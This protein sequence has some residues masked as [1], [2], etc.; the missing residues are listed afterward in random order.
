MCSNPNEPLFQEEEE[1]DEEAS[2]STLS[3]H[4]YPSYNPRFTY[5][6]RQKS[7]LGKLRTR[8]IGA[9]SPRYKYKENV[10]D[11]S[12][13]N[14]DSHSSGFESKMPSS[15][16]GWLQK[17]TNSNSE[18]S[19]ELNSNNE[20][21]PVSSIFGL[22]RLNG[23]E[24]NSTAFTNNI[25]SNSK[26]ERAM[27]IFKPM[28][29]NRNIQ[30]N[31]PCHNNEDKENFT[32]P[33]G[34]IQQNTEKKESYQI[35]GLNPN[36]DFNILKPIANVDTD[37]LEKQPKSC[38]LF[39]QRQSQFIDNKLKE[40]EPNCPQLGTFPRIS[41]FDQ[42]TD[43]RENNLFNVNFET[44]HLT[45][46][47]KESKEIIKPPE[48][49]KKTVPQIDVKKQMNENI[50]N[51]SSDNKPPLFCNS[52]KNETFEPF[53]FKAIGQRTIFD[54]PFLFTAGTKSEKE[55]LSDDSLNTPLD[56]S[57]GEY[58]HK[59][60]NSVQ[61]SSESSISED[62]KKCQNIAEATKKMPKNIVIDDENKFEPVNVIESSLL[63][64]NTPQTSLTLVSNLTKK[65]SVHPA[66]SEHPKDS[67][68]LQNQNT[69]PNLS[70]GITEKEHLKPANLRIQ[71]DTGANQFMECAGS[72][73]Y[74]E[75]EQLKK[76]VPSTSDI[77]SK[78]LK[79]ANHLKCNNINNKAIQ[80][81]I[82]N[83]QL[84]MDAITLDNP[85]KSVG[86]IIFEASDTISLENTD[87]TLQYNCNE[88]TNNNINNEH[89]LRTD[90]QFPSQ[91]I[92][93]PCNKNVIPQESEINKAYV[94]GQVL[95]KT[96]LEESDVTVLPQCNGNVN[97]NSNNEL[98]LRT[99]KQFSSQSSIPS[100]I[101]LKAP[102]ESV[103][104]K[105]YKNVHPGLQ[106]KTQMDINIQTMRP[107][108]DNEINKFS[109]LNYNPLSQCST[110]QNHHKVS[111]QHAPTVFNNHQ[112]ES[113]ISFEKLLPSYCA[114]S[115]DFIKPSIP[116]KFGN[117]I[118]LIK[119]KQID[120]AKPISGIQSNFHIPTGVSSR[121]NQTLYVNGRPY[122]ILSTLGKGGSSEV[123]QVLDPTTSNLMAVKCVDLNTVDQSIANGYLNEIAL[124]SRL[125]GCATVIKMF[126]HEYVKEN[127]MLYVVM[128]KG[129]TDLSRLIRDINKTAK[130]SMSMIIYYW[131]EMLTAVRDIHEKGI[132]HSDL[133]PAN[134][135][136]VSGR[137]KLIDFGIA[138]S[139][140]GDMT[141]VQKESTTGTWNYMSPEAFRNSG[142]SGQGIKITYRSDVWSLGC[143]LY[144]LIYGKTP[145]SHITHTWNK[146]QAIADPNHQIDFPAI[147][148]PPVLDQALK[149]C[150][151]RDPKQRPTVKQLLNMPY[152]ATVDKMSLGL[153]VKNILPA[154]WWS[155]V[156]HLFT[157]G[158][159]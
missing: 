45:K 93:F 5:N 130:I 47:F 113:K 90:K 125:Q 146:L 155:T 152:H 121:M 15:A 31:T 76:S 38:S 19:T 91:L 69:M 48:I 68:C 80:S 30:F 56:L 89:N 116:P 88:S 28:N 25:F 11:F 158:R 58:L 44:K 94:N 3:P 120:C 2:N 143:I 148:I 159:K 14:S 17:T 112:V 134:F 65:M 78:E 26:N 141:S 24:Y 12:E 83:L 84:P 6:K 118:P 20:N 70:N 41:R 75:A 124:L 153:Q 35:F 133:K 22:P 49:E 138:S 150:F 77:E 32:H 40:K 144:N 108:S 103:P 147:D 82:N 106:S 64:N 62:G 72:N 100:D 117:R 136:L 139:I 127:K 140:Q 63:K 109:V 102:N 34:K 149:S 51:K 1:E 10:S 129:D 23:Q 13:S 36:R 101:F 157:D 131:T 85:V 111:F 29:C 73:L 27:S 137:L 81:V 115:N 87:A 42:K 21:K 104:N 96:D 142:G 95:E 135:L 61:S 66:S 57:S 50:I 53:L 67:Y 7:N 114:K 9:K 46:D 105:P 55:N 60:N 86:N 39:S 126:A 33:E 79:Q 37:K 8:H 145:F 59:A 16:F 132:I 43:H 122:T 119:E 4:S 71:T 123:Y 99:D 97:T 54:K 151:H 98:N 128:E 74:S 52:F 154:E 110:S 156:E 92:S 107:Q 18:I